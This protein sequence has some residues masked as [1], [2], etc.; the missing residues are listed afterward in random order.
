MMKTKQIN[1]RKFLQG[2]A[3]CGA[4][5]VAF[6]YIVSSS[7]LGLGGNVAPSN[8]IVHACIGTGGQGNYDMRSFLEIDDVQIV[9]VCDVDEKRLEA[10][11]ETVNKKYGNKDCA[12]YTDFRELLSRPDIDTVS[13]STQDHWHVTQAIWACREGKDVY[14]QKPLSLTVREARA[15]VN[16]A[17]KYSRVFQVGT[18]NRSNSRARFGCEL[19]RNDCL[20]DLRFVEVCTWNISGPCN[21]PAEP[22]PDHL[23]WDMWLGPAPWRP[24][25][26]EIHR[27]RGWMPFFDYSGGGVTDYGA[28][29]YDLAQWALGTEDT[30]P[31]EVTPLD[32]DQHNGRCVGFK[33]ANGTTM[34]RRSEIDTSPTGN[35]IEFV[36][37]KGKIR[38]DICSWVTVTVSPDEIAKELVGPNEIKLTKIND[39]YRNF[40]ECVR[41]R[42]MPAADVE[43][44]CRAATICHIGN[45]AQWLGRPL[46]WDPDKELFVGDEEANRHL[47]RAKRAPWCI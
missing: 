33:Y 43:K 46:K 38:M 30:G 44:G 42:E 23:N 47:D 45:I 11:A 3:G 31:V 13:I 20:G 4:G 22:V 15:A 1:R 34:Y 8:R 14:C 37:T 10:A 41:T 5:A 40:I 2:A 28:H 6:P 18:Q 19:V 17:R 12:T 9:A 27:G 32:P 39:H 7:A 26:K 21:L 16:A 29:F 36:G 35:Y 25:N 24:Y